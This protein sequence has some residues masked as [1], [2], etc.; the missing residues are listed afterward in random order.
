MPVPLDAIHPGHADVEQYDV[1]RE[2][3]AELECLVTA[4]GLATT[5]TSSIASRHAA[6]ALTR[7]G[8]SS[9][10]S[11]RMASCAVGSVVMGRRQFSA[12]RPALSPRFAVPPAG[13]A[14]SGKRILT[15]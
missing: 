6:H 13:P 3:G 7:R 10:I 12:A 11:V 1:G 2:L 5:T 15:L 9:T 8:S 14:T 4:A